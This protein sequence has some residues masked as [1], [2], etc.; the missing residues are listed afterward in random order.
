[1]VKPKDMAFTISSNRRAFEDDSY[2]QKKFQDKVHVMIMI[3]I[4]IMI[5]ILNMIMIVM[6]IMILIMI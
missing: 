1:M 2:E 6:M 3:L 4:R 5:I